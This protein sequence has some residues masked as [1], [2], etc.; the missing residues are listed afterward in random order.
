MDGVDSGTV[1]LYPNPNGPG[2]SSLSPSGAFA[3]DDLL[4]PNSTVGQFV[5]GDGLLFLF[6]NGDELNLYYFFGNT[7]WADNLGDGGVGALSV[8]TPEPASW[9]LLGSGLFLL[10]ALGLRTRR[11]TACLTGI[12]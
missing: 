9:L 10:G 1:T 2:G 5:D 11:R 4:F 7:D 12:A 3:Y 6:G 8:L